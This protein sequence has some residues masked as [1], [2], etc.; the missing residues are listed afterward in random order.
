MPPAAS[1]PQG[2]WNSPTISCSPTGQVREPWL[3]VSIRANRYS[4]QAAM[5]TNTQVASSP[6][7]AI[8]MTMRN[9]APSRVT[10]SMRAALSSS[11]GAAS[12]KPFSIQTN[13]GSRKLV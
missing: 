11:L 3:V 7:R 10:P 8:G 1:M 12:K 2:S 9:I 13:S 6:L 5:A 4:F